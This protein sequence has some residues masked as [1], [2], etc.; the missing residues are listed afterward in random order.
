VK[1][2]QQDSDLAHLDSLISELGH[3]GDNE[4][5]LEHLQSARTYLLGAMPGEYALSLDFASEAAQDVHD[6]SLRG[7]VRE[8]I[9]SLM[10]ARG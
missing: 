8:E 7:R 1:S 3:G 5:L 9:T 6:A 10:G 4:L 2:L